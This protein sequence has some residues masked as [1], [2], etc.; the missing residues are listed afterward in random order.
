LTAPGGNRWTRVA[1]LVG[2]AIA[3]LIV[4]IAIRGRHAEMAPPARRAPSPAV[5]M[6][7]SAA[8]VRPPST[9]TSAAHT[10]ADTDLGNVMRNAATPMD[11]RDRLSRRDVRRMVEHVAETRLAGKLTPEDYDRLT[12]AVMRLRAAARRL[13]T[14]AEPNAHA[15]ERAALATA[16]DDIRSITGVAPSELGGVFV[17]DDAETPP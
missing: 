8:A 1:A 7:S 16:L 11:D 5:P 15:G 17:A 2:A 3:A 4:A 13:R 6:A 9:E 10:P 14:A 12:D